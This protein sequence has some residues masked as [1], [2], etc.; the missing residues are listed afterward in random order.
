MEEL[1]FFGLPVTRKK[2]CHS[3]RS[4][5]RPLPLTNHGKRKTF[6]GLSHNFFPVKMELAYIWVAQMIPPS[7]PRPMIPIL[8]AVSKF[9]GHAREVKGKEVPA[10]GQNT[11]MRIFEL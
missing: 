9:L 6:I 3:D 10:G 2:P 11:K 5:K 1:T 7:K 4:K 8:M